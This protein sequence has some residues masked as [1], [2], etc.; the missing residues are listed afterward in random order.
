VEKRVRRSP[1]SNREDVE[2]L[3]IGSRPD[4]LDEPISDEHRRQLGAEHLDR[5]LALVLEVL[6]QVDCGHAALPGVALDAVAAREGRGEA[7]GRS[8][9][10]RSAS[11]RP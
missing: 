6:G 1:E 7:T 9:H 3:E 4:L 8:G 5:D 2:V 10:R 11:G